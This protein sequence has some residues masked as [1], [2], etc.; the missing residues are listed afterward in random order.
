MERDSF[1]DCLLQEEKHLERQQ[2]KQ[3]QK[4]L[5][6]D[7]AKTETQSVNTSSSGNTTDHLDDFVARIDKLR[8]VTLLA[9]VA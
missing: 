4:R 9:L 5:S 2:H 3:E 8:Q 1:V 6:V 7:A